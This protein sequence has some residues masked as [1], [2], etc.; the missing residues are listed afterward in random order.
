MN[1][2]DMIIILIAALI[3]AIYRLGKA[4]SGKTKASTKADE[5]EDR[6]EGGDSNDSE[7]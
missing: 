3:Y 4:L 6:A 2:L 1:W 7:V 5:F